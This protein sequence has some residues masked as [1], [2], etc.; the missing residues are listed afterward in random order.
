MAITSL[1]L[2][3][4]EDGDNSKAISAVKAFCGK[5]DFV[6]VTCTKRNFELTL[7]MCRRLREEGIEPAAH[8]LCGGKSRA[9]LAGQLARLKD[10]GITKIVAL[11]GDH[12]PA[13]ADPGKSISTDEFVALIREQGGFD[14]IC[15]AGYPNCHPE[16]PNMKSDLEF[17]ARK[18]DA[19]ATRVITQVCFD[20]DQIHGFSERLR[21]GGFAVPVSAGIMPIRN[22]ERTMAFV[23]RCGAPVPQDLRDRFE[24]TA[25]ADRR[26]LATSMLAGLVGRLIEKGLDL[27]Y[28]TLNS[29]AMINESL[30]LVGEAAQNAS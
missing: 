2:F 19:G 13:G 16:S 28:Y 22:Y 24:A 7:D 29:V 11:R 20:A 27:H 21:D 4:K 14:E 10:A 1:E 15:V 23:E 12:Q 8:V 30:G 18:I 25:E 26:D 5:A 9:E 6:S 17:L 3:P